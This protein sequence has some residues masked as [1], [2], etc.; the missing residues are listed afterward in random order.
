MS[1]FHI[2]TYLLL[3]I[4]IPVLYDDIYNWFYRNTTAKHFNN[5]DFFHF[6]VRHNFINRKS[7]KHVQHVDVAIKSNAISLLTG[8]TFDGFI[9][10]TKTKRTNLS[11]WRGIYFQLPSL[12]VG[13]LTVQVSVARC[14]EH[15]NVLFNR[16]IFQCTLTAK[17]VIKGCENSNLFEL[18]ERDTDHVTPSVLYLQLLPP[19]IIHF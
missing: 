6:Q 14:R 19:W 3:D 17:N 1:N 11:S 8:S 18:L 10:C 2:H 5:Y 15:L 9:D 4:L 16:R 7:S 12:L 13:L